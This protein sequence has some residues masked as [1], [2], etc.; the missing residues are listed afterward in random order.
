MLRRV[1]L[2]RTIFTALTAVS[3]A[4]GV[5]AGTGDDFLAKV[6]A[7]GPDSPPTEVILKSYPAVLPEKVSVI[8]GYPSDCE[9]A[10]EVGILTGWGNKD[11]SNNEI[12][13]DFR[14]RAGKHGA[15]LVAYEPGITSAEDLD[16]ILRQNT[17]YTLM[18]CD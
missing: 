9:N 14:Q 13:L 5:Y 18:R 7:L 4:T 12:M 3:F 1:I 17:M 6:Y 2:I 16:N 8:F 15:N 10:K 11:Q